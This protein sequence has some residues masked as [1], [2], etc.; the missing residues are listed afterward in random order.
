MTSMSDDAAEDAL[1][2]LLRH[3]PERRPA[4]LSA[5]YLRDVAQVEELPENRDGAD[6]T[7]VLR[8]AAEMARLR[9]SVVRLR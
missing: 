2:A 3:L 5:R 9:R 8:L 6:K 1:D 7:W 4:T